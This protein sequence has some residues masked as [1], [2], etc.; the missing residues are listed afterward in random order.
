MTKKNWTIALLLLAFL[1]IGLNIDYRWDLTNDQ[2]YTLNPEA[3]SLIDKIDKPLQINIFLDGEMT[4][5][6]RS[7][8]NEAIRWAKLLEEENNNIQYRVID[9]IEEKLNL[10]SLA[11]IGIQGIAVPTENKILQVFPFA[12]LNYNG[13]I[14]SFSILNTK[15]IPI[16]ERA[17]QSIPDIPSKFLKGLNVI[18]K[19]KKT[20]IGLLVHHDELLPQYLDGFL[21]TA[22]QEFNFIPLTAPIKNGTGELNPNQIPDKDSLSAII[23]AKP[24]KSFSDND[25]IFLDQYI[26]NGGNLMILTEN[27]DAEM[28]SLFRSEKIVS[29]PRNNNLDDLL[30]AYGLRI[31]PSI[32]KDL[33][34]AYI[35]L[36]IGEVGENTAYEQFPW[37]YF[38]LVLSTKNHEI[39]K[40][41]NNP[42]KFEFANPIEILSREKTNFDILLATSPFTQ[43]QKP[44]SYINFSEIE[45]TN[46]SNYP[47]NEIYPLAVLVSGHIESAYKDRLVSRQLKNFK[48]ETDKG[49]LI[50]ISDGDFIKNHIFRGI[51]LP[52]GADKYSLRPDIKNPPSVIYDNSQFLI[53][54]LQFMIGENI[55]YGFSNNSSKSKLLDKN[56]IHT[57]KDTWRWLSILAPLSILILF[58]LFIYSFRKHKFGK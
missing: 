21:S 16:D 56:L 27:V 50:L 6:F 35:T 41:L 31:S 54:S 28:D 33:Q 36:A 15:K 45:N 40:G 38:P 5:N 22:S 51:P 7:L 34:A 8:K 58:F 23:S 29:F 14:T 49:K 57:E 18:T 10:D 37:P 3:L 12:S 46:A 19:S 55:N 24:I 11:S 4:G 44:L 26:M 52:L 17:I 53:N 48:S 1:A 13:K 32:I 20:N 30:F 2:R 42:L 25:K 39:N 9:P 47:E 43:L